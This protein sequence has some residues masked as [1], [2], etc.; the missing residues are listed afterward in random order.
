[1]SD[2]GQA[3]LNALRSKWSDADLGKSPLVADAE[4]LAFEVANPGKVYRRVAA[5]TAAGG[6]AAEDDED[7]VLMTQK[8][9][10]I[11]CPITTTNLVDPVRKCVGIGCGS[12]M[13]VS[14]K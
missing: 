9:I 4:R 5:A 10:N 13:K 1:M 14:A 12:L 8:S 11:V 6:G 7:E 3:Q 2:S